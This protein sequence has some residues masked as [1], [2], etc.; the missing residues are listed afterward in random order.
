[1]EAETGEARKRCDGDLEI[2]SQPI[3]EKAAPSPRP[4]SM[5][6]TDMPRLDSIN[7][8]GGGSDKGIGEEQRKTKGKNKDTG[9][10]KH[11]KG[12]KGMRIAAEDTD[13]VYTSGTAHE[14]N[15]GIVKEQAKWEQEHYQNDWVWYP[16]EHKWVRSNPRKGRNVQEE[17]PWASASIAPTKGSC[18]CPEKDE[19]S[20]MNFGD[21][22]DWAY[23][24]IM[25]EKPHCVSYICN[26][27]MESSAEQ[28]QFQEWIA[29]SEYESENQTV[30]SRK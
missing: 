10:G 4:P 21:Y 22:Q 28:Q 29:L 14:E 9:G 19:M 18:L 11:I 15:W 12:Q 30:M 2:P 23:G 7:E 24:D 26:E 20:L 13:G 27:S 5:Y 16:P 1:M 3:E 8:M 25:R 6:A 17:D